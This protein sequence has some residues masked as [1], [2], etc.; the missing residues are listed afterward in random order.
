MFQINTNYF[1]K[2]VEKCVLETQKTKENFSIAIEKSKIKPIRIYLISS[3]HYG[4]EF[5]LKD[6]DINYIKAEPYTFKAKKL[7]GE[8]MYVEDLE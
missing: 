3:S 4:I 1:S 2:Y 6:A 7:Y 5:N 8:L